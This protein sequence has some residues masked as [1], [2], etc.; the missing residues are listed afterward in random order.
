V[1]KEI[2]RPVI[3]ITGGSQGIGAATALLAAQ[4]GYNICFSYHTQESSAQHI[5]EQITALGAQVIYVQADVGIEAD[6]LNL[7][8]QVDA[9]FGRLDAL[10]NNAGILRKKLFCDIEVSELEKLFAVNVIGSFICARE[11]IKRMAITRGGRGG[12]IVNVSSIA[13]R[14]GSPFEY[15]DYAATKGALDTF[16]IGLAKEIIDEGIRVNA[17]RPGIVATDIHAKGG[18]PG[19]TERIAPLIPMQRAGTAE[20]I[21]RS[22]LWL[23]SDDASYI[24]G[25]LL[26]VSGGR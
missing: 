15:I 16:T 9:Y 22:I 14:I 24:T 6:V 19:R 25:S 4:Q 12:A 10:V 18:E 5:S 1:N 7:F 26:D 17:V 11:A 21:A 8:A 2:S 3:L 23:L 13:S 20:E